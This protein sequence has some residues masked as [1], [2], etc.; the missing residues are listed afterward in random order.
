MNTTGL[1][2]CKPDGLKV[3][4]RHE[5]YGISVGPLHLCS[6]NGKKEAWVGADHACVRGSG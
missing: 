6:V 3:C 4:S 2:N 5:R 1:E